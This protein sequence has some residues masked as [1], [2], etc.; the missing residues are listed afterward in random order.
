PFERVRRLFGKSP[1]AIRNKLVD[2]SETVR[3]SFRN[4]AP[5]SRKQRS[6]VS[7]GCADSSVRVLAWFETSASTVR[8]EWAGRFETVHRALGNSARAFRKSAPVF[9][10]SH[11][12]I[13]SH[14][15]LFPKK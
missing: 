7:K 1:R 8:R 10:D 3:R 5:T 11:L 2:C 9:Q 6:G 4:T 15:R 13:P 14:A 12:W